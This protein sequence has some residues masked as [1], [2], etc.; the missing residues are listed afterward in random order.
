MLAPRLLYL[1]NS[2]WIG[3]MERCAINLSKAFTARG[4]SVRSVFLETPRTA[5]L[6]AWGRLHGFAAESS[7]ALLSYYD[8]HTIAKMLALRRLVAESRADIVHLHGGS[9]F[10]SLKDVLALRLSGRRACVASI[11]SAEPW[12]SGNARERRKTRLAA[13]MC[14]ALIVHSDAARA[15]L[16]GAGVPARKVH[17]APL[18][19]DLP[20]RMPSRDAA[21]ARLGIPASSFVV[22]TNTRLVPHKGVADLIE[23]V[24]RTH[25]PQRSVVLQIA[26]DGP[27][28][29]ALEALAVKRLPGRARFLG[30]VA[31]H[32]DLYA[33]SDLFAMPTHDARESFG[34]VFVE[35][36]LHGVPSIGTR[37]GGIPEAI[38]DGVTGLLVPPRAPEKLAAAIDR[39]RSD[40]AL[41]ARL[42][43]AASDRAR[44]RFTVDRMTDRYEEIYRAIAK[45]AF[46]RGSAVGKAA[47]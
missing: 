35:A 40:A 17:L 28:R 18:G 3:G 23:A 15:V 29:M 5:D 22:T 19:V 21:R 20:S 13:A 32:A 45:T 11:H 7:A 4:W 30:H 34:I 10:L 46:F 12:H 1:T 27:E 25:D 39:L 33:A 41:R 16:L 6:L 37:V 24:V 43:L 8:P 9:N 38:V 14:D 36:A 44:E 42:G 31:D 2:D 47:A 26:G